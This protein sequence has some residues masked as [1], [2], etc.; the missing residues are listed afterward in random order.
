MKKITYKLNKPFFLLIIHITLI[1]FVISNLKCPTNYLY[2]KT[3]TLVTKDNSNID[4]LDKES[5][6]LLN[7]FIKISKIV[8]QIN[9]KDSDQDMALKLKKKISNLLRK[10]STFSTYE[11]QKKYLYSLSNDIL[12]SE[13]TSSNLK[14]MKMEKNKVDIIIEPETKSKKIKIFILSNNLEKSEQVCKYIQNID[15]FLGNLESSKN[16]IPIDSSVIPS[17]T[18]SN[19]IFPINLKRYILIKPDYEEYKKKIGYKLII[20]ENIMKSY[21]KHFL[22]PIAQKILIKKNIDLVDF[23]SFFSHVVL[24]RI[25]HFLGP[26]IVDSRSNKL[27]LVNESMGKYFYTIEE[28][29]A[30]TLALHNISVLTKQKFI[31]EKKVNNIYITHII[32]LLEKLRNEPEKEI[33]K[34]YLIQFN[35]LLKNGGIVFNINNRKLL[36]NSKKIK[37]AIKELMLKVIEIENRGS[38]SN[39]EK[40]INSYGSTSN[41]LKEIIKMLKKI[42]EEF[43]FIPFQKGEE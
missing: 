2:S 14:W 17:I 29:K 13:F 21:F 18:V 1:I 40:L 36:I 6:G 4:D 26:V 22:K 16:Q 38:I 43:H 42:P 10:A 32:T 12:K 41:E 15:K 24:H 39:A 27:I 11:E 30:D 33:N 3:N 23:E 37:N 35:Y 31:E 25:S 19:I 9:I 5:K 7:N 20:L 34:A 8:E 28:I